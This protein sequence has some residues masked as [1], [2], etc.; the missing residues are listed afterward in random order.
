[1]EVLY[2]HPKIANA[3]V[4]GIPDEKSGEAVKAFVQ[5]L[6]GMK[7]TQEEILN[8]C[9]EHLAGYKRPRSIEFRE[10]LPTSLI[11]KVLRRVLRQEELE[12]NGDRSDTSQ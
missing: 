4:V 3:A 1:E 6:P 12:K 9:K 2:K 5:L 10:E 11:G 7:V 8:F